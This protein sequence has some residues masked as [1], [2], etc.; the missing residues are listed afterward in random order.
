M[1]S[2]VL[3]ALTAAAVANVCAAHPVDELAAFTPPPAMA[4]QL[5]IHVSECPIKIGTSDKVDM[6]KVEAQ[7][8][9]TQWK[10]GIGEWAWRAFRVKAS[11]ALCI[12]LL[13]PLA[14]LLNRDQAAILAMHNA[15]IG[16]D[17]TKID[18]TRRGEVHDNNRTESLDEYLPA[19]AVP[20]P[21]QEHPVD[22]LKSLTASADKAET[23]GFRLTHCPMAGHSPTLVDLTRLAH[24]ATIMQQVDGTLWTWREYYVPPTGDTCIVLITPPAG[25]LNKERASILTMVSNGVLPDGTRTL[26]EFKIR[27]GQVILMPENV[28]AIDNVVEAA[29]EEDKSVPDDRVVEPAT[30]DP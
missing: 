9:S 16:P 18:D 7:G 5:G 13:E 6:E 22:K 4:A 27:G 29:T 26:S 17:G 1:K 12:E 2:S 19:F 3:F 28:R 30:N 20:P 21:E 14:A 25:P 24:P 23:F 15:R 10:S 8:L 11:G